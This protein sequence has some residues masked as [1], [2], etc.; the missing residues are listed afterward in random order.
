[1]SG[2]ARA[3]QSERGWVSELDGLRALAA[4][5]VVLAHF[6]TSPPD[7]A[8]G[9]MR[10]LIGA[11]E[12]LS[13]ANLGVMFFF[14]LSAFLLTYIGLREHDR[15]GRFGVKRFYVRRC[16][17][18]WPL[19]FSVLLVDLLVLRPPNLIKTEAW[20]GD[21]Q[22]TWLTGHVWMFVGFVSNWSLALNGVS[23][24][25]DRT[26]F[27]LAILWSIGVEEQ[28]YALYPL[29]LLGA[30]AS[31][32]RAAGVAI[33]V[34]LIGVAGRV[35]F[36]FLP[37]TREALGAAGGMYYAT[38]TYADTFVAGS[39]AGWLAARIDTTGAPT[40]AMM[41][42]GG[43]GWALV[44]LTSGLG[45]LWFDRLWHPYRL[46]TIGLYTATGVTFAGLLLW[47]AVNRDSRTSR[48]LRSHPLRSL[49]LLSY[50][51][52][53]WHPIGLLLA[54]QNLRSMVEAS[55]GQDESQ[56]ALVLM[57]YLATTV[58]LA[59]VGYVLV[60]RPFL[61]LKDRFTSAE[62]ARE[63]REAHRLRH[64]LVVGGFCLLVVGAAEVFAAVWFPPWTR[65]HLASLLSVSPPVLPMEAAGLSRALFMRDGLQATTG[66]PVLDRG[67]RISRLVAGDA[68]LTEG[69]EVLTW[70]S[71]GGRPVEVKARRGHRIE[72]PNVGVW[73]VERGSF[74]GLYAVFDGRRW[75]FDASA[76]APAN[77]NS[78]LAADLS[79]DVPAGFWVSPSDASYTIER[80]QDEEGPFVRVVAA[81]A[82]PYLVLTTGE[83]LVRLDG[84]PLT[85]RAVI[86]ART[87][88]EPRLTIYDVIDPTGASRSSTTLGRGHGQWTTLTSHTDHTRFPS[89]GD[90]VSIG[91]FD[92]AR[93][94]WFDVREVSLVIG[95]LP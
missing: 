41:R 83:P 8:T 12:R 40:A 91:L 39:V 57:T 86:R 20:V 23:G 58:M 50:G 85:A 73:S 71:P 59:T 32:R 36:L 10:A 13:L 42:R 35:V 48:V 93:G 17:R 78:R 64:V 66:A 31:G 63:G 77:S 1:M 75:R 33:V 6:R 72:V 80:R 29:L 21:G 82:G 38:S 84:P 45:W 26:P 43:V 14:T 92:V 94:D 7:A 22:W 46:S 15:T 49:G 68:V 27:P 79:R 53:L 4:L 25:V 55:S 56:A 70:L 5:S 74:E 44:A 2:S 76:V 19:Y 89:G 61:R 54:R 47:I 65:T 3:G 24:Y 90:N 11:L 37:V 60:E 69:G 28:F 67:G 51:I 16:L 62:L 88:G 52:Y 87:T 30:L 18:I 81:R 95:F 34:G 9:S